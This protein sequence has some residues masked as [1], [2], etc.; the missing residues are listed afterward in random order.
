MKKTKV[1]SEEEVKKEPIG[2]NMD[3][4]VNTIAMIIGKKENIKITGTWRRIED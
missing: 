3:R 2:F 4:V 1:K